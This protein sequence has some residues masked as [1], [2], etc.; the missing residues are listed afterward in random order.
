MDSHWQARSVKSVITPISAVLIVLVVFAF[1][2]VPCAPA[3]LRSPA[4]RRPSAPY[5]HYRRAGEASR[6]GL[7]LRGG[8]LEDRNRLV[9]ALTGN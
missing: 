7:P 9:P 8:T 4:A 2:P 3:P 1:F 5:R 6:V